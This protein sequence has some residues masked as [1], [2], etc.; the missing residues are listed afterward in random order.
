MD[1]NKL[2]PIVISKNGLLFNTSHYDILIEEIL[3]YRRENGHYPKEII[4]SEGMAQR[5]LDHYMQGKEYVISFD[6]KPISF[7]INI[8]LRASQLIMR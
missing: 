2:Q 5:Y 4:F 6:K 7:I 3:R 1:T 8:R